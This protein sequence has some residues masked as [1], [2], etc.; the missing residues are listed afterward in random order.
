MSNSDGLRD[1][2]EG[3]ED[4]YRA[5]KTLGLF[6]EPARIKQKTEE[7]ILHADAEEKG[8]SKP[9]ENARHLYRILMRLAL[10]RG[11]P[12]VLRKYAG[13]ED[14]FFQSKVYGPF[15]NKSEKAIQIA[16]K[17]YKI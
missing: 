10:A 6:L 14:Q 2:C 7:F 11:L 13:K 1:L 17:F 12:D 15:I 16:Q 4:M 3:D 9:S 5:F 8:S